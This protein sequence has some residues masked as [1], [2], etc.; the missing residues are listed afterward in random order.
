MA[1]DKSHIHFALM[2]WAYWTG[3]KKII[4]EVA[5]N[6]ACFLK[7]KP[8]AVKELFLRLAGGLFSPPSADDCG[9]LN[10]FSTPFS[11]AIYQQISEFLDVPSKPFWPDNRPCAFIFSCDI[12]RIH[13]TYQDIWAHLFN[14]EFKSS[15]LSFMEFLKRC[16][17][18]KTNDPYR[19]LNRI[20]EKENE[21]GIRSVIFILKEKR[22]LTQLL[23]FRPQHFFGVYHPAEITE[24]L[25]ALKNKGDELALHV[26]FDGFFSAKAL[27]E[28][29]RY[30]EAIW[31]VT[32]KGA[33]THY[34][35]FSKNTPELLIKEGFS[36]DSSMGFNFNNGF[37]CGTAFPFVLYAG[38]PRLL[39]EIPLHIM[40]TAL[41]YQERNADN[42]DGPEQNCF[43]L[44]DHIKTSQ[45]MLVVNW[46]QRHFNETREPRYFDLLQSM[47][48]RLKKEGAWITTPGALLQWW[49]AERPAR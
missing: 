34:L 36:Y 6:S 25:G 39:W 11:D 28:E 21:W 47:I 48:L 13:L 27:R 19:N 9:I 33:R 8:I 26:S 20:L 29:K 44:L 12:D 3:R 42:A 18:D 32:I 24:E 10:N 1:P 41:M 46:H 15:W 4:D 22:R 31:P 16:T 38:G 23:R 37:R 40:D 45:G 14:R 7:G 35:N 2:S 30:M 5:G 49:F 43:S 17:G